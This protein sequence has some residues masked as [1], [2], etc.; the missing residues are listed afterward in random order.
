MKTNEVFLS[1]PGY[2]GLYEV[3]NLGNV[4]SLRSG[5]LLKQSKNRDGYRIVSLTKDGKS[6]G[7]GVHRLVAMTFLPNP[8]GL[9]EVN[10]K[11]ET[12]DNN[13]LENLEWCSRKYN[14][15]YG[16]YR[17]RMSKAIK[18][19]PPHHRSISAYDKTS[20]KFY[21]SWDTI[22][23]AEEELGLSRGTIGKA[24]AGI[25]KTSGG[26]IWKYNRTFTMADLEAKNC[27]D[28]TETSED[29]REFMERSKWL[30]EAAVKVVNF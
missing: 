20:K 16:G 12:R 13:V 1:V 15:N 6:K 17:E 24:L 3:S 30:E 21:K 9:P 27:I 2:V 7:F 25:T 19:N 18:N 23:E 14:R 4:M 22:K 8:L 26:Y 29:T 10:H 11:D 28:I 5:K